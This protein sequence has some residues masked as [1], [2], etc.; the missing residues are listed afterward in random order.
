MKIYIIGRKLPPDH[1]ESRPIDAF[2][3]DMFHGY[4]LR[5][6]TDYALNEKIKSPL[7]LVKN[8]YKIS[9][10]F[11]PNLDFVVSERL[12]QKIEIF[13]HITLVQNKFI[14]K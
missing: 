12:K 10:L 5:M 4:N 2:H 3:Y 9:D 8:A 7:K 13:P 14:K 6:P 1:K 11:N